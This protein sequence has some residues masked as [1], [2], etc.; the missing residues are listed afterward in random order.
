MGGIVFFYRLGDGS[1]VITVFQHP[2]EKIIIRKDEKFL[3][4]YD[5][6][7]FSLV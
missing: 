1:N 5:Q 3:R 7:I 6:Y 4:K 2:P